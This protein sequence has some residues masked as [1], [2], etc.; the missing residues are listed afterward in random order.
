MIFSTNFIFIN[1]FDTIQ[2]YSCLTIANFYLYFDL[3]FYYF[4][5]GTPALP[6]FKYGL[7]S[8]NFIVGGCCSAGIKIIRSPQSTEDSQLTVF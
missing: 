6:P 4:L 2:Y 1:C 7:Y 3:E 5:I 8:K